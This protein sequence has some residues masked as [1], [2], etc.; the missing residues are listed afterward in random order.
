MDNLPEE[1]RGLRY[2]NGE[3]FTQSLPIAAFDRNMRNKLIECTKFNWS[4]ISPAVF[5]AMF[6]GVMD[7][8]K[9]RETGSHYTSEENIMKILKPLFLDDL[10]EEFEHKKHIVKD[11]EEFHQKIIK[12]TF[13]D[14]ACGCGNFLILAY[15]ELRL[16]EFEILKI[17]YSSDQVTL[18]Q[19]NFTEISTN[20]FYGIEYEEFSAKVAEVS[21]LL[22]K[23]QM[24]QLVSHYFGHNYM[25]FPIKETARIYHGNA[26]T[27]DWNQIIPTNNLNYIIGNP[28]FVGKSN[29]TLEQQEEIKN[30]LG[31]IKGYGN[32]D[33]V[34]AWFYK[35]AKMM[36]QNKNIRTALVA[37]NS[38]SQGQSV[39]IF[40]KHMIEK[41]DIK[42]DFAYRTF[43]WD[44]EAKGKAAVHC[45]IIGFSNVLNSNNKFKIF[46]E[47]DNM[48]LVYKINSYLIE[49]DNIFIDAKNKPISNVPELIVGS[50]PADGGNLFLTEK[51]K[52]DIL[53]L[54]PELDIIIKQAMG[55]KDFLNNFKRYCLWIENENLSLIKN[56][57]LIK[58]KLE[59]VKE[60]RENS[61]NLTLR[62]FAKIP[63][64]FQS[65][66]QPKNDYLFIPQVSSER[67]EY[68]PIGYIS[69]DIVTLDPNFMLPNANLYHFGILTS[70]THMAWMRTV[71]GRLK[72]DFRYSKDL[73]YNT[74]PWPDVTDEMKNKIEKTGQEILDVREKYPDASLADLYDPLVMPAD[75]R[76]AHNANDKAVWEA[77]GKKWELGN[78]TECV[79][80]LMKLYQK[81]VKG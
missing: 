11:L 36:Q 60:F 24:D 33:Y 66:R 63:Y 50:R 46:D 58:D 4:Y 13:L 3:L 6:Q 26:I 65:N 67:R 43:R 81:E 71:A 29:Q 15:R 69:K 47:N 25:D 18:L 54:H 12:L 48:K 37:T 64:K 76:A 34:T 73:V 1:L 70:S 51:E 55:G 79:A 57:K 75:L 72:S 5:G 31:N 44:N 59:R 19:A 7:E 45:V 32:L 74:F 20:N 35:S 41:E 14:P 2:I 62:E 39:T 68:I 61:K 9:R 22:M 53:I 52:E 17:L 77:Y 16:L 56:N 10:W 30:I 40:W 8:E 28:P 78:E 23:H 42:I 80:Y 49:G 38:I 27:T 21:M